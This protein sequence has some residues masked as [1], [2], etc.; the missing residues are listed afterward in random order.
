MNHS[1]TAPSRALLR[2]AGALALAAATAVLLSGCIV[3]PLAD[4]RSPFDDPFGSSNRDIDAAIPVVQAALDQVDTDGGDWEYRATSGSDDCE[5]ACK[6][7]VAVKITPVL[8]PTD[9]RVV[10]FLAVLEE[11]P[12]AWRSFHDPTEFRASFDVPEQVLRDVLVAAV[13][14][15]E[16]QGVDLR[17]ESGWVLTPIDLPGD[18]PRTLDPRANLIAAST[19]LFGAIPEAGIRDEAFFIR[20]E[21]HDDAT[22][23]AETRTQSNVLAAMGL[24]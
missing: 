24:G 18:T 15:A 12:D 20:L 2:G 21:V 22:I 17:V 23:S 1:R 8:E 14:A 5:G 11:D 10:D 4:G 13:P 19:A 6:L 16:Q 7:H 3:I 9:S